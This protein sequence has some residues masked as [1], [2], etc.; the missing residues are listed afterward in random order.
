M[1]QLLTFTQERSHLS[2]CFQLSLPRFSVLLFYLRVY[3]SGHVWKFTLL[4]CAGW[5]G[6]PWLWWVQ[7]QVGSVLVA[8]S[9]P[10]GNSWFFKIFSPSVVIM[11]LLSF[12]FFLAC[13]YLDL[14][15]DCLLL[16]VCPLLY[17]LWFTLKSWKLKLGKTSIEC[18]L[19]CASTQFH[20]LHSRNTLACLISRPR[21]FSMRLFLH[22]MWY[23]VLL[24]SQ[25]HYTVTS[26]IIFGIQMSL[27]TSNIIWTLKRMCKQ[28]RISWKL[29]SCV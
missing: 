6:A 28:L 25:L 24:G 7:H 26:N 12:V 10:A 18:L 4:V 11:N 19:G 23:T 14:I 5:C 13:V 27:S 9:F 15:L 8:P 20:D 3:W 22:L 29:L 17:Q 1:L 2:I 16:L 21:W